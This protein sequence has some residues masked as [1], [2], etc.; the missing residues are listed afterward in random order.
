M[1][2]QEKNDL[3]SKNKQMGINEAI[4]N[5]PQ[6]PYDTNSKNLNKL[7]ELEAH[8]I[9]MNQNNEYND[10]MKSYQH[11]GEYANLTN[12][13]IEQYN[14]NFPHSKNINGFLNSSEESYSKENK[15]EY[16]ETDDLADIEIQL[17][18]LFNLFRESTDYVLTYS[19][20]KKA[21]NE[22]ELKD[23][24]MNQERMEYEKIDP[25]KIVDFTKTISEYSNK[26][27]L[28]FD[29]IDA[30]VEGLPEKDEYLKTEEELKDELKTIRLQQQGKIKSINETVELAQETLHTIEEGQTK[31]DMFHEMMK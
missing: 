13:H 8:D 11:G 17:E 3:H 18:E 7:N 21:N 5:H 16:N 15:E 9:N 19:D 28:A 29:K 23:S 24:V 26:I 2:S 14:T 30:C 27:Q 22:P 31:I 1:K 20:L 6:I 25:T 12:N 10:Y 4:N